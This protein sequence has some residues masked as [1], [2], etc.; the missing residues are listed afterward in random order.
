M[1]LE[2]DWWFFSNIR[3]E[4]GFSFDPAPKREI[5]YQDEIGG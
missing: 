5:I 2:D 3:N 1:E 4:Q